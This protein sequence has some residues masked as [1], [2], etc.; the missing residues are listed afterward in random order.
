VKMSKK[1]AMITSFTVGIMLF[2]TTAFAEVT[3]KSGYEQFKDSVK[4][5]A[6]S[7]TNKL[8]NYTIDISFV[9]KDNGKIIASQNSVNKYDLKKNACENTTITTEGKRKT[10]TIYYR[11][12]NGYVNYNS[13]DDVY[14][15]VE[16]DNSKEGFW[17]KNPFKEKEAE[18]L[19]K[20]ADALIGNLKDSVIVS[21]N[22][23]NSKEI[24]VSLSEAQ[25]PSLINAVVSYQIKSH[26]LWQRN[27]NTDDNLLPKITK[28]VFI[29]EAKGKTI[30]DKNG[31]IQNAL[32]TGILY[33]K[34]DKGSEHNLTFEFL[35]KVSNINSTVVNKPDTSGKK[36]EKSKAFSDPST[37]LKP[38]LYI[39]T[40]KN[41]III[42]KD[43]KYQKIGERIVEIEK[44]DKNTA[45]GRYHE[46]YLKGYEEY[47]SNAKDFKF[48]AK[49]QEY[50]YNGEFNK[51]GGSADNNT[52]G[53]F[54]LDPYSASIQFTFKQTDTRIYNSQFQRVFD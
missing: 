30:V 14:Y 42:E 18:D 12:K 29:K 1:T 3:S 24:S 19:E 2:A 7:F 9:L 17:I 20:I 11:D 45:L 46:E 47:L 37:S 33:G 6:E 25:I 44:I 10:E 50:P 15:I 41:N 35:F 53:Y 13:N 28:D 48:E 32:G 54:G 49:F 8:S 52:S 36:V 23:D 21:E 4:Y 38:E 22:N 34:D 51:I 27:S 31:L 43:G 39:G 40:Y 26:F 5:S 16:Q